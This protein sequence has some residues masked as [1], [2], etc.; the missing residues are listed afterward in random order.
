[1]ARY[2]VV[3]IEHTLK[4]GSVSTMRR[5]KPMQADTIHVDENGLTLSDKDGIVAHFASGAYERVMRRPDR[6][7]GADD[8][9][10]GDEE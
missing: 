4:E 1:M 10:D 7:N 5:N 3:A 2:T 6:G 8:S 9:D